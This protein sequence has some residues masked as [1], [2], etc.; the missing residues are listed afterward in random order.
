MMT[1][2]GK[3]QSVTRNSSFF[4]KI[5]ENC[6]ESVQ[7]DMDK[8]YSEP[9]HHDEII[10]FQ[11]SASDVPNNSSEVT[12]DKLPDPVPYSLAR[13]PWKLSY[14]MRPSE[15]QDNPTSQTTVLRRSTRIRKVELIVFIK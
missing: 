2:S 4:M 12:E 14:P 11:D 15:L 8:I 13:S 1:A 3:G 6:R 9:S 10:I 7:S 5:S